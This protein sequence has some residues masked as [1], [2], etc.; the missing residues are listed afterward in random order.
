MTPGL[1]GEQVDAAGQVEQVALVRRRPPAG[2]RGRATMAS[3][4]SRLRYHWSVMPSK[5]SLPVQ[6]PAASGT[7]GVLLVAHH[8]LG[9]AGHRQDLGGVDVPPVGVELG[10]G[11]RRVAAQQAVRRII[12]GT[13]F[14]G[15]VTRRTSLPGHAERRPTTDAPSRPTAAPHPARSPTASWTTRP[16]SCSPR[17]AVR[18]AGATNIFATLV[19]HPGLFRGGC[20][21]AASCWRASCRPATASCSS[22]AP[23]GTAGPT[24]SGPST[25]ASP[26]RPACPTRRSTGSRAG[27]D[28]A[29]GWSIVDATLLRAADELHAD[30][31]PRRRHLGGAGRA[32]RRAPAHRGADGGGALPHDGVH[33]EQPGRAGRARGGR[34]QR[35]GRT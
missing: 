16:A 5:P 4:S 17:R 22:C 24:T 19:R 2:T 10:C 28:A 31:L 6:R 35:G 21:S 3:K 9:D 7:P 14:P 32:L 13:P 30:V 20:R 26:G 33:P 29:R 1:V 27:P 18:R 34:A 25:C 12:G 11:Q 23:G 15:T 8:P